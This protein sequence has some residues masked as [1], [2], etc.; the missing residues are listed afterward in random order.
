MLQEITLYQS[1]SSRDRA[2][3]I[4]QKIIAESN[5]KDAAT[6]KGHVKDLKSVWF[7]FFPSFY[8][9]YVSKLRATSLVFLKD[10]LLICT[11]NCIIDSRTDVFEVMK[12]QPDKNYKS[13]LDNV[14]EEYGDVTYKTTKLNKP[15]GGRRGVDEEPSIEH[16]REIYDQ[17]FIQILSGTCIYMTVSVISTLHHC[18]G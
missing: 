5:D 8:D 2:L 13:L 16:Y 14:K 18:A 15:P 3:V 17:K 4:Q 10:G 12:T 9:D 6:A 1:R 7:V 11:I